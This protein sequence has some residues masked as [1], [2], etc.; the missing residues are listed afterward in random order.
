LP[1]TDAEERAEHQ[2]R[3]EQMTVNIEKMRR[4]MRTENWKI[5]ISLVVGAAAFAGAGIAVGNYFKPPPAPPQIII[6][7]QPA[8]APAK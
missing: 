4:D 2:T 6:L 8:P 5:G 1:L 7:Q 3:M